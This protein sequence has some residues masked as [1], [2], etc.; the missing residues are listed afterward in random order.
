MVKGEIMSVN[1]IQ[2]TRNALGLP[3]EHSDF[4]DEVKLHISASLTVLNQN[5]IGVIPF[6]LTDSST[7]DDFFDESQ[8][9]GNEVKALVPTYVFIKTKLLFDPPSQLS[10]AEFYKEYTN[11]LLWRLN[12][13]YSV[14][15]EVIL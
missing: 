14:S 6:S 11:E 7:W 10:T 9:L 5:G 8:V 13:A 12:A 4:E 15:E 2:S 1:I 3:E